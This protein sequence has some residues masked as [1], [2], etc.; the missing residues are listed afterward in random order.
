VLPE[1]SDKCFET[2]IW[3]WFSGTHYATPKVTVHKQ[4]IIS[5]PSG[6]KHVCEYKMPGLFNIQVH[7]SVKFKTIRSH[8]HVVFK[9]YD[10]G[11][12]FDCQ[13]SRENTPKSLVGSLAKRN[14]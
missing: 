14:W 13:Q 5:G 8:F 11:E 10:R 2:K 1:K 7:I 4:P 3:Q 6:F 9:D 12:C